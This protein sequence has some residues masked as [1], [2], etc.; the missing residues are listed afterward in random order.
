MEHLN[1]LPAL[2]EKSML[3]MHMTYPVI[4]D[5]LDT[6][7]SPTEYKKTEELKECKKRLNG[8]VKMREP[9]EKER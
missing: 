4:A 1:N 5:T 2:V 8:E 6:R 9:A 3:C 7:I